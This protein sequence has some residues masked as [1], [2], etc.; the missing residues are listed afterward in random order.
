V[1]I[2]LILKHGQ[3]DRLVDQLGD[4]SVG[5]CRLQAQG[6]VKNRIKINGCTFVGRGCHDVSPEKGIDIS[7]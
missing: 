3:P 7:K 1:Y 2:F 6:L 4:G 5:G